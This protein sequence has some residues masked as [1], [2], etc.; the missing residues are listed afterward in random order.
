MMAFMLAGLSMHAQQVTDSFFV[1]GD[2]EM[3]KL[4]IETSVQVGGVS[5]AIWLPET[6]MLTLQYDAA[7][8]KLEKLQKRIAHAGHDTRLQPAPD[9][10]YTQLPQCCHYRHKEPAEGFYGFVLEQLPGAGP[11]PL[12]GASITWQGI[13]KGQ[14]TDALGAFFID[15]PAH[16]LSINVS[17]AGY[18]TKSIAL[19]KNEALQI[20]LQPND[21]LTAVVVTTSRATQRINTVSAIRSYDIS[22]RELLKAACCNLSESFETNPSVDVSYN[23][24][25]TGSK[26]IQLLG[27]AG[28]YTQLT[29]ENLPGPRGLATAM[30]LNF[31]P[32]TWVEGI[33]LIKGMGSVVNG[34]ES[35]AG[36]I[37]I[38][39]KKPVE[40]E[41]LYANVYTNMFG[42]TDLNLN[43][44][45]KLNSKWST[46]LLLHDA[47]AN[48]VM[49]SNED[50]FR[51][52]PNGNIFTVTN[53]WAYASGDGL[54][55]EFGVRYLFDEK[56][57]GETAFNPGRDKLTT[58]AYGLQID[59]D[60][61]EAFA[62][63]GYVDPTK[64]YKS[65]GL[66]L[67]A[68]EHRQDAYYGLRVYDARQKNFYAN[69]IYQSIISDT[70]HKFKTGLSFLS[71]L[72][73]EDFSGAR[74]RRT[75]QVPGIFA[76]YNFKPTEN[77]DMIAGL[78]ADH[79]NLYGT[80]VS[81]RLNIR[82]EPVK[83][84]TIRLS[85]G[86]GQRTAN[87]FAEN[88]AVLV[89]SRQ[90]SILTA[91]NGKAYGLR[92]EASWNKG[93]SIDQKLRLFKRSSTLSFDFFRND[94]ENQVVVDIEDPRFVKFYNLQGRSFS[95]SLQAELS[96]EPLKQFFVRLAYRYFDVQTSYSGR[97]LQKP[98]NAKHR[99]FANLA[100]ETGSWKFDYTASYTGSKRIP[101]TITNV[102]PY[103]VAGKS[104]SYLL[105][106]MQ[107]TITFGK[108]K[109]IDL[110]G[111]VENMGNFV[112][113]N[114]IIAADDPFGNHFDA[115]M[116][117][118][119]IN[120]A[121]IYTGVRF[122]LD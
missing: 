74:Y 52:F 30:G 49:D 1:A 20:L 48:K 59:I 115:S 75:E 81:P 78:R 14:F 113:A 23:D 5:S 90:V 119:P 51:D 13:K 92:P 96:T 43:I 99:A 91:T 85:G 55:T 2:C 76:E 11:Q 60:R 89:S 122:A 104:P 110:Y 86:R 62:K 112:Q 7:T 83:G 50:G 3:C 9:A 8:M 71:D 64:P 80:F 67:S 72:Y 116:I 47:F 109:N 25:V 32:G 22:K 63:F 118:G 70:R 103:R 65:V 77:F 88:N 40:S 105:M 15:V 58:N 102:L 29:V 18:K 107:V 68:Y 54:F 31:I 114:P 108:K 26:Q 44:S 21:E 38:E 61:K 101:S 35:I 46:N 94:F 27:L 19:N 100:Y 33:Q 34:F 73:D 97:L 111:G 6:K 66:Q 79:N 36:Q 84:T 37:N 117:W 82:F 28:N 53:R 56:T 45:K 95:N 39:L 42:K 41:K 98:F 17:Y 4:R 16:E 87:I 93:I 106:N 24:A 12:A 10:I 69:L 120:G 57:G 121:M